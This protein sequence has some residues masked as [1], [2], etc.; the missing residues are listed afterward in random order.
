MRVDVNISLAEEGSKTLGT[1]V[2]IKNVGSFAN[3]KEAIDYEIERQTEILKNGGKLIQEIRRFDEKT[4]NTIHMREKIEAVD[5]KYFREPNIPPFLITENL[6][7][8]IKNTIPV[9]QFDRL[10]KYYEE[11]NLPEIDAVTIVK[12]MDNANYYENIVANG[13]NPISAANWMTGNILSTL[14]RNNITINEFNVSSE[15]IAKLINFSFEFVFSN[16]T[17]I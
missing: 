1:K 9:L 3:V 13:A 8:E 11:Y 10:K 16:Y 17:P 14:N 4:R 2:E 6:K 15:N 5:Y 7:E 12:E